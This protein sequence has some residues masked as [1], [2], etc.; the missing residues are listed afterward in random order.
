MFHSILTQALL[1]AVLLLTGEG[2]PV[3]WVIPK[4]ENPGFATEGGTP[5]RA[6]AR[7]AYEPVEGTANDSCWVFHIP[8]RK[9]DKKTPLEFDFSI[10]ARKGQ[11]ERYRAE[12][13][14][15]RKWVNLKEFRAYNTESHPATELTTFILSR[16][17]RKEL[18]VRIRPLPT[19]EERASG[20]PVRSAGLCHAFFTAASVQ[21]LPPAVPKDTLRVLILGNS[22]TYYNFSASML[23][24]IAWSQGRYL[25]IELSTKGGQTF[26]QHLGLKRTDELIRKGGYDVAVLQNNTIPM[27]TFGLDPEGNRQLM[28]DCIALVAKIRTFSPGCRIIIER[29]WSYLAKNYGGAGSREAMDAAVE[30]ASRKMAEAVGGEV[31]PIGNASLTVLKERPDVVIYQSDNAHPSMNLSYLK[32]CVNY[33]TIFKLSAFEKPVPTCGTGADL[34]TWLRSVAVRA[35]GR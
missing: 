26:S 28:D 12:Y 14:D 23:K 16:P 15:G 18:R 2:F 1:A 5:G 19:P 31:S 6:Q 10:L 33:L 35:T 24:E 25:D 32:S 7:A 3:K 20:R 11:A 4:G 29:G 13:Y 17:I 8:V 30:L 9:L 22:N 34:A 21:Q 27:T